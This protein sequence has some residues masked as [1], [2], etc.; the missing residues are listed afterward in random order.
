[1]SGTDRASASAGQ[2]VVPPSR[3]SRLSAVYVAR[4][5]RAHTWPE[6]MDQLDGLVLSSASEGLPL[7][8]IWLI[9]ST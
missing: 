5:A 4:T 9:A 8:A 3:V 2:S 6:E 7:N 1:M